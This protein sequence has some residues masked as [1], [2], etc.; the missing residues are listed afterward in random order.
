LSARMYSS[1]FWRSFSKVCGGFLAKYYAV[2][3]G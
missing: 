3:P 1:I 2:D